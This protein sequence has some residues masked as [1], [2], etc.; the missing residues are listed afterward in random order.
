M[1][2]LLA[3]LIA[4]AMLGARGSWWRHKGKGDTPVAHPKKKG[5]A[6]LPDDLVQVLAILKSDGGRVHQREL[7]QKLPY[8]EAKVSMMLADLE[9]RGLLKRVKQ[10]RANLI[11]LK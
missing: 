3:M 7:R 1:L 11:V 9:S 5:N 10:G 6:E 8:S 2:T 4:L